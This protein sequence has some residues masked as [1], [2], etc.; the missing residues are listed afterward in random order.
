MTATI[1]LPVGSEP[2]PYEAQILDSNLRSVT[3][4]AG[5]AEIRDFVTT[6]RATIDLSSVPPGAYQLAL[7]RHGEDWR[8]FPAEVK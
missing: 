6:L 5:D 3:S 2:G 4:A 7:R 1:L 8:L